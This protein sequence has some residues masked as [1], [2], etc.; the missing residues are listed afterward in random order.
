MNPTGT[1]SGAAET[2]RI[3]GI[4]YFVISFRF[5]RFKNV[6]PSGDLNRVHLHSGI[7]AKDDFRKLL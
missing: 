6:G 4:E 1:K 3:Y 2:S 7:D 5:F